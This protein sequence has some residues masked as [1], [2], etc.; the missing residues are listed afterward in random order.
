M[1]DPAFY[2]K[3]ADQFGGY[4]DWPPR[5]AHYPEGDPEEYFDTVL[6][7]LGSLGGP[8]AAGAAGA[9]LLDV[10][11][12]D[13]R[14]LLAVADRFAR[15]RGIDL[16]PG[17][18]EAARR[19][20]TAS[21]LDHVVFEVGDARA[22]GLPDASVDVVSSRRGPLFPGEFHRVLTGRG[23]VVH[24]G[25][26]E[27]DVRALKEAFGRG[28]NY[29]RWDRLPLAQEGREQLERAGFRV[30]QREFRFDEYFHSAE[31]LR[32]FLRKVPIFEDFDPVDDQ[33]CL[34]TFLQRATSPRGIHLARHWFVLVARK[35][36]AA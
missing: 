7:S 2:S 4:P 1:T 16:S 34:D 17:M 35:A 23:A 19:N 9:A 32:G 27:Q 33:R 20:R 26:G 15:V 18:L 28:Q 31:D 30:E 25:I 3:V 24:L 5:T 11:C 13:G 22:T 14:N 6:G 21:G 10:G 36:V 8:G 29:G 12:A